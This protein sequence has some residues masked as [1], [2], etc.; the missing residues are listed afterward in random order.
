MENVSRRELTM[1]TLGPSAGMIE[2]SVA[3]TG[4]GISPDIAEQLFQPFFTTKAHGLGVGLSISRTIIENHG[5]K[6]WIEPNPEGG[7][8]FRLT[9]PSTTEE[10]MTNAD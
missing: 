1:S 9:L 7:T 4:S 10:D 5:G 3:D 2:I 8:I 6:I